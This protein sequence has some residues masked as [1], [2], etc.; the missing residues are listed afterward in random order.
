MSNDAER[1]LRIGALI[2]ALSVAAGAF[3]AHALDAHPRIE[4]WKTAAHYQLVHGV[5]LCLPTL[6][7][8]S[9]A[10]LLVGTVVFSGSLYLLVVLDEPRLGMVTPVGGLTLIA[11]WLAALRSSR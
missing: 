1:W 8:L 4:T 11:G 9:R 7:R 6:P 2:A 5:A 3:G 10:L